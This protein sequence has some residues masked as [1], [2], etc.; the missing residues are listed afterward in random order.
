M[1]VGRPKAIERFAELVHHLIAVEPDADLVNGWNVN[2]D[3]P[4]PRVQR[5][6]VSRPVT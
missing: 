4:T 2:S 6:G 3:L 5:F 1:A